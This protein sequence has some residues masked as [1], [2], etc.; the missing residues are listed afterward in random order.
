[1]TSV[2]K[3]DLV[4]RLGGD[5]F[6]VLLPETTHSGAATVFENIREALLK[7][8]DRQSW[9]IGVSIGVAVFMTTPSNVNEA[10]RLAD[11][12]MYRV[13]KSGKNRM[14]IEAYGGLEKAGRPLD[15]KRPRKLRGA[16]HETTHS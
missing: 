15:G 4:G 10:I 1:L 11:A 12:L 2:R 8:A 14:L 3:A 9:P 13:K 5:E 7:K 16:H 6:V